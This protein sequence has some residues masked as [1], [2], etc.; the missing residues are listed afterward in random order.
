MDFSMSADQASL[1]DL[2][3]EV[4]R[5]RGAPEL[6]AKAEADG[7]FFDAAGWS[8]LARTELLGVAIPANY[9]GADL[10]FFELCLVLEQQGAHVVPV[11]LFATAVL[12]ALPI[13]HFGSAS[14]KATWLPRVVKGQAVLT[15]ALAEQRNDTPERPVTRATAEADG[16]WRLTGEKVSVSAGMRADLMLVSATGDD[17]EA[18]LFAVETD[19]PG[20]RRVR[21][22]TSNGEP[23]AQVLLDGVRVEADVVLPAAALP[24]LLEHARVAQCALALGLCERAMR[25]TAKYTTERQQFERPI[26]TFQAVAH[27]AA[28][29]YVDVE[30]L[31]L[32][33]LRAAWQLSAGRDARQDAAVARI[34]A[35]NAL[36]RVLTAAQHLHG[37][38]GFD[39]D[40]P[41]YRYY[42]WGKCLETSLGS[43]ASETA[44]LGRMLADAAPRA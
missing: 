41:L 17:G 33:F 28:D 23:L 39:R 20:V 21:Q 38:M 4:F 36:H 13:A 25:L 19:A 11:P 24:F 3:R 18:R 10:G 22:V 9:G 2:A 31:R 14:L 43:A 44:R 40:Y 26:A 5:D 27:R 12:G 8:A 35:S 7:A 32:A 29:Q 1:R 34:F 30:T 42:L 15:A 6:L 16:G 37:G